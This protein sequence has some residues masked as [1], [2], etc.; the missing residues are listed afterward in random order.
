[1]LPCFTVTVPAKAGVP[2]WPAAFAAFPDDPDEV[3]AASARQAAAMT[4]ALME[5]IG[6]AHDDGPLRA[7]PPGLP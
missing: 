6:R 2:C 1:L 4:A 7:F 5:R 3:Q